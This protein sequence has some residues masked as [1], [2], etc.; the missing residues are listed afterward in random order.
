MTARPPFRS[1]RARQYL[2]IRYSE[3]LASAGAVAS[4]G[5]KGDSYDNAAASPSTGSTRPSSS[6][7]VVQGSPSRTSSSRPLS[8]STDTTTPACT[9]GAVTSPRRVRDPAL[10]SEHRPGHHRVGTTE[11]PSIPGLFRSRFPPTKPDTG[12]SGA[13]EADAHPRSIPQRYEDRHAIGAASTSSNTTVAS[14]PA[15]TRRPLRRDRARRRHRPLAPTTFVTGP[16]RHVDQDC[17]WSAAS[18]ANQPRHMFENVSTILIAPGPMM[19]MNSAGKMH[20]SI[21]KRIFTGTF[22]AFSSAI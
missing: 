7:A 14:P 1:A 21:G 18:A 13:P 17:D 6:D 9:P 19:T 12:P 8:E 10:P 4:V 22:C 3:R 20:S 15:N 16:G 11:P 2:A 5:S